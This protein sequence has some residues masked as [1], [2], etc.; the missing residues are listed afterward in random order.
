[1]TCQAVVKAVRKGVLDKKGRAYVGAGEA[2]C[3]S[4][5]TVGSGGG[6]TRWDSTT[7]SIKGMGCDTPRPRRCWSAAELRYLDTWAGTRSVG[8]MCR[9]LQRSERALRCQLHRR[10][11]SAKVCEGWGLNQLRVD[12]HLRARTV[13]HYAVQGIL[14]VHS[15]QVCMLHGLV[16]NRRPRRRSWGVR[17][18]SIGEAAHVLR[19]SRARILVAALAGR[20]RLIN[21]RI[22]EGS[23]MRLSVSDSFAAIR[24]RLDA[25]IEHWLPAG[26]PGDA[27]AGS[28]SSVAPHLNVMHRCSDCGRAVRGIAF[29]RH[30][31]H[32]DANRCVRAL[33]SRRLA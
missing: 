10:G 15:A 11:L 14:R 8:E 4:F 20:C 26:D 18:I 3:A 19:W 7:A 31:L 17:T 13:L 16:L 6:H 2:S 23:V 33:V 28:R 1:M 24:E 22:T 12:L 27:R 32:C 21:V 5:A 29:Y 30:R 9:R 25:S